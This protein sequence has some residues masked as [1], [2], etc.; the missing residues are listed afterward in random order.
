MLNSS[1]LVGQVLILFL[2]QILM[3]IVK[4]H[5]QQIFQKFRFFVV[6]YQN[7]QKLILIK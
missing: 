5:L 4:K 2:H 6:I 7:L 1:A 3:K